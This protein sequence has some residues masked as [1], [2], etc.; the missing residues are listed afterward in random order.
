MSGIAE[1][2]RT[3]AR[4]RP[5]ET[6]FICGSETLTFAAFDRRSS[7]VANALLAAELPPQSR[8]AYLARNTP[9]FYELMLGAAKSRHVIVGI[10]TRLA[11]P[12]IEWILGDAGA[13]VLVVGREFYDTVA[14][15][16]ERLPRGTQVL[17]LDGGHDA[18]PAYSSWR[19]AASA[20]DPAIDVGDDDDFEQLYTS[21]T[22]GHPKGVQLT[23]GAFLRF[24]HAL[25]DTAWQEYVAGDRTLLVAP[26]FHVAGSNS[27]LIALRQGA[28]CVM[29]QSLDPQEILALIP[30]HRINH[31]FLVP[32]LILMLVRQPNVRE[33][34][35]STLKGISYG[36]SPIAQALLEEAS[37]VFGCDF[38][39]LYGLTENLGGATWLPP[40]DHRGGSVRLRSCGKPYGD[41]EIRIVD[42]NGR[43]LPAGEIG[44][45]VLR[46]PWLMKGYWQRDDA[47]RETLRDGWLFTG[48]AGYVDE[49]GY[50]YI[51]DR[52]KDMIVTGGENVYPAEVENAVFS[53]PS[54]A[55]V[56]V[57]GVPDEKWGET[58]KAIVV[59]RPGA[60]EDKN[61]IVA[62]ARE[63]IAGFKVPRSIEFVAELPR[64]A[65]GK[66][67]RREL[68]EKYWAGRDRRV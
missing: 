15:F 42:G 10:N 24:S 28:C 23:H 25:L 50:L 19:D 7:R 40:D 26:V 30:K 33:F 16:E 4:K 63:Q 43:E 12:E 9:A 11:A 64:N 32:A 27:G 8:V 13:R 2:A 67:L 14:G 37:D 34:D 45:I 51:H 35:F 6:A 57:I 48:D 41:A 21:G 54:V 3:H 59:L 20:D 17:A 61:S 22:T 44:E 49:D 58:V 56:A 46:S 29:A 60:A 39:Q 62:H 31:L 18:W 47:T 36:A 38:I 5:D 66:V 1:L 55:D 68:R 65:S 53:H 52:I